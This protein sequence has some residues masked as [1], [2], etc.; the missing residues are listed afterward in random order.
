MIDS[1]RDAA[2]VAEVLRQRV[3]E[4]SRAI[5]DILAET[6]AF[7]QAVLLVQDCLK[8][9]G[10]LLLCGN[11]GNASAASHIV[12]DFLG[13]M[14]FDRPSMGAIC[15]ADNTS[16]V[17]AL[18]NDYGYDQIFS[19]QLEGLG[20][21]GDV[22]IGFSTS[23]NS[24]NVLLAAEAAKAK[25]ISVIG[26]TNSSGGKLARVADVWLRANSLEAVCSEHVHLIMIHTLGECV[27]RLLYSDCPTWASRKSG[28]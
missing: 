17:T 18:A 25:G 4:N 12:N 22:L 19:R 7:T 6:P 14:Y 26:L 23:G 27:E 21:R 8:N 28:K 9:G 13:H 2:V 10:K 11:G 5:T 1:K 20:R 16:T 15:L 3:D 24:P